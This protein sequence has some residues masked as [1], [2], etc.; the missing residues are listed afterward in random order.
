MLCHKPKYKYDAFTKKMPS[1]TGL[2][3][4]QCVGCLMCQG[5]AST[6]SSMDCTQC[7]AAATSVTAGGCGGSPGAPQ[8]PGATCTS[9]NTAMT[10]AAGWWGASSVDTEHVSTTYTHLKSTYNTQ[11]FTAPI[12]H[13]T[14]AHCLN[15]L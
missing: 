13:L 12:F 5:H 14:L 1:V 9:A 6:W 2:C 8:P 11:H 4:C 7:G 15:T 3:G 10:Q